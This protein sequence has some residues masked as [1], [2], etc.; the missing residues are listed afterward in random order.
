MEAIIE[1]FKNGIAV[2][3]YGIIFIFGVFTLYAMFKGIV[4]KIFNKMFT[5]DE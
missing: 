5:E 2:I 4:K 1:F 3:F